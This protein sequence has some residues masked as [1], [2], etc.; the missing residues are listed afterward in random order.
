MDRLLLKLKIQ[1][2]KN[3]CIRISVINLQTGLTKQTVLPFK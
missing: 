1:T 3:K 2:N